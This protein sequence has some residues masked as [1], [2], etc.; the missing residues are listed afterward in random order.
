MKLEICNSFQVR[1]PEGLCP[2][3][4]HF[5]ATF[6]RPN[7]KFGKTWGSARVAEGSL[8]GNCG[9]ESV[10]PLRNWSPPTAADAA[11]WKRHGKMM[12]AK[13]KTQGRR[14]EDEEPRTTK[15]R[16]RRRNGSLWGE[17][18]RSAQVKPWR[19]HELRTQG[20]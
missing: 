8:D 17:Y 10:P 4:T 19:G 14:I 3:Q 13:W 6:R 20:A 1:A 18:D 5:G 2:Q 11:S 15:D 12:H 16:A 9:R 7:S